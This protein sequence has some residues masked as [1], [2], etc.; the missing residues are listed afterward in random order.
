MRRAIQY[1]I[2]LF[3]NFEEE[4]DHD[5]GFHQVGSLLL[6]LT[7]ERMASFEE[8]VEHANRNGVEARFVDGAQMSWRPCTGPSSSAAGTSLRTR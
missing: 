2:D 6:A 1:A 5:P 8:H 3:L 7:P 4:T